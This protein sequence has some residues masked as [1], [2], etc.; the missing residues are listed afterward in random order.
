MSDPITRR[1]LTAKA[2]GSGEDS[3]GD[4]WKCFFCDLGETDT[5]KWAVFCPSVQGDL[6]KDKRC[7][8]TCH[9]TC[10]ATQFLQDVPSTTL[11]PTGGNCPVCACHLFWPDVITTKLPLAGAREHSMSLGDDEEDEESDEDGMGGCL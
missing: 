3:I 11:I 5:Q 7:G 6:F 8:M 2:E 4:D 9:P 10:L 1:A